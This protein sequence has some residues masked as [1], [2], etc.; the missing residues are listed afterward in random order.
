MSTEKKEVEQTEGEVFV[1]AQEVALREVK[2]FLEYHLDM[3][4]VENRASDDFVDIPKTYKN[5][6]KAVKRGMLDLSNPDAP[7]LKLQKP[8]T[9]D[10]GNYNIDKITFK[11][12]I[13]KATMANLGRGFDIAGNTL[14]FTNIM[15]TYLTGLDSP[16]LLSKIS[17][18]KTD[19]TTIDE[20][21]GL[22][23]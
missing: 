16:I 13:T 8:L 19:I 11:T 2:A 4:I 18:N 22:F 17:E 10:G 1:V 5:I 21:T 9:S 3:K 12:R 23:Q 14:G 20:I 7:V 6:L 15:S